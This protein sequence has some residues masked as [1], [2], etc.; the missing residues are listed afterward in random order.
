MPNN[1]LSEQKPWN[2]KFTYFYLSS[3]KILFT[4]LLFIICATYL[5]VDKSPG[6]RGLAREHRERERQP[7]WISVPERSKFGGPTMIIICNKHTQPPTP[8]HCVH[9]SCISLIAPILQRKPTHLHLTTQSLKLS[10]FQNIIASTNL[11]TWFWD[12]GYF[13]LRKR[14]FFTISNI[15]VGKYKGILSCLL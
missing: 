7:V 14:R 1:L 12:L 6:N 10:S 11:G 2:S 3:S 4:D 9:L 5:G 13:I 15:A 8:K